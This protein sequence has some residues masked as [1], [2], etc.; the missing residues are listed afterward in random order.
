MMKAG[1]IFKKIPIRLLEFQ[2][3]IHQA[4]DYAS[5]SLA[6]ILSDIKIAHHEK[7]N[8]NACIVLSGCSHVFSLI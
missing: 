2:N 5:L 3:N 4:R 1:I 6:P 7:Y 8:I